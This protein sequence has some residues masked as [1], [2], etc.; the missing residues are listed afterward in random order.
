MRAGLAPPLG[1]SSSS[2]HLPAYPRSYAGTSSTPLPPSTTTSTGSAPDTT[3]DRVFVRSVGRGFALRPRDYFNNC[4]EPTRDAAFEPLRP[5]PAEQG[6]RRGTKRKV[7][8]EPPPAPAAPAPVENFKCERDLSRFEKLGKL[9]EGAFGVVYRARD[10]DSGQ[11]VALKK[12]KRRKEEH[13]EGVPLSVLREIKIGVLLQGN[14]NIISIRDIIFEE[15]DDWEDVK[16]GGSKRLKDDSQSSGRGSGD[17]EKEKE[18]DERNRLLLRRGKGKE[19]Y[20]S[21]LYQLLSSVAHMHALGIIH[22][23]IKTNNL[24]LGNDGILRLTDFGLSREYYMSDNNDKKKN[25]DEW[26]QM[27]GENGMLYTPTVVTLRYRSMELLL[28][29]KEYTTAI[30]MWSC[31][32]IFAELVNGTTTTDRPQ[33]TM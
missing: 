7:P 19:I 6:E 20:L 3:M 12:M 33:G 14:V 29:V 13:E 4:Y 28:G 22:R 17:K 9:E 18:A 2:P 26:A 16:D 24:L 8:E 25:K 23:D 30:D 10:K 31:G 21:L 32:V 5:E 27:N 15:T 1:S 11:V